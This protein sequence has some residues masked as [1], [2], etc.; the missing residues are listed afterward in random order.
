MTRLRQIFADYHEAGSLETL[1][2]LNSA[3]DRRT[4]LAECGDLL[5]VLKASPKDVECLEPEEIDRRV[6]RFEGALKSLDESY[7]L[8]QYLLKRPFAG[9]TSRTHD[10][11]VVD[12]VETARAGYFASRFEELFTLDVYFVVAYAGWR[13]DDTWHTRWTSWITEPRRFLRSAL[14]ERAMVATLQSGLAQA[15]DRLAQRVDSLVIQL[16]DVLPLAVLETD[17]A[18]RFFRRLLNYAPAKSEV[19]TL[20]YSSAIGFQ[21]A[22]SAL[23]CFRDHLRL[24]DYFVQVLSLK[25]PPAQTFANILRDLQTVPSSVVIATD[26]R[27]QSNAQMRRLI[28]S[29]R[30]HFF[31]SKTS[32]VT[33]LSATSTSPQNALVDTAATAHVDALGTCLE[34]IEVN[35][36]HFGEF[37]LTVV[38]Y[39]HDFVRLKR[40]VAESFKV[41][42][43]HDGRLIEERYNLLNAYLAVIPGNEAYNLRRE[44][45]LDTHHADLSF[46]FAPDTGNPVNAHLACEHLAVLES[47]DGT[48]FYLNLHVQDVAHTLVLGA[49]GSGKSFLL[50]FLVT[51]LQKYGPRTLIFDL[52][53][54]YRRMTQAF[55]GAYVQIAE[56][57]GSFSIN[58]FCLEPTPDHLNFLASFVRVLIESSGYAMSAED[59]MDL[60]QQIEAIYAIDPD[61]RRLLTLARILKRSLRT[62]LEKWVSGG[63]YAR[64]FDNT[65]D[66]VTLATFQAFD[67]EGTSDY[68]Q[69]LEP[70]VF[71]IL[72]RANVALDDP[73]ASSVF[74]V[75]VLDEAWRFLRHPAIKRYVI[76]AAKTWRKKNA[77]LI[78][79]TQSADDL[80]ETQLLPALVESCP[81]QLFLANPGMDVSLYREIFHLNEVEAERIAHLVPKKQLLIRQPSLSKVVNLNVDAMSHALFASHN[82]LEGAM[83]S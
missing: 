50:N 75:F 24:D 2:H 13:P 20:K 49:T 67:F 39:D 80:R 61:E 17:D 28:Q 7:R 46:L 62:P 41:L 12:R 6:R 21:A 68:A 63:P 65:A 1:V 3:V 31:N 74:K 47:E 78:L 45:L 19:G 33:H 56:T 22:D 44:F 55:G 11:P 54:S 52:G 9:L 14:S 66:T 4:F 53:G 76:E 8:R 83:P 16:Q 18:F 40:S 25:D 58:P 32:L 70:L 64:W 26:W 27:R 59:E 71:H 51:F 5:T 37:S 73:A 29:K 82:R 79:A 57:T 43:A 36:R 23:E 30:R 35:G 69:V 10:N 48:P 15:R 77:A 60:N 34:E 42:A 81:T 72:H 38:L